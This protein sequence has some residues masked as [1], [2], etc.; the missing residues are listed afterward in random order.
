M[1][2]LPYF[3]GSAVFVLT[4]NFCIRRGGWG[5]YDVIL[6]KTHVLLD[7]QKTDPPVMYECHM[8]GHF[9]FLDAPRIFVQKCSY[10]ASITSHLILQPKFI[11]LSELLTTDGMKLPPLKNDD[12]RTHS[13]CHAQANFF[14]FSELSSVHTTVIIQ[15][16]WDLFCVDRTHSIVLK[17]IKWKKMNYQLF[18]IYQLVVWFVIGTSSIA[19]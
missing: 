19:S 16:K 12:K 17:L 6:S 4:L 15:K 8:C 13:I 9:Y 2:H 14:F 7:I 5:D 18:Y 1:N 11:S 3:T 10:K